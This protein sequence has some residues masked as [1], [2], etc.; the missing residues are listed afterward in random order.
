MGDDKPLRAFRPV[1]MPLH[2][3][4]WAPLLAALFAI[5]PGVFVFI[6]SN[7][8]KVALGQSS[9]LVVSFGL[10]AYL[11]AFV[12]AMGVLFVMM[13]I[14]PGKVVYAVYP[15]RL[16][17]AEGMLNW[18]RRTVFFSQVTDVRLSQ[19]LLQRAK[20]VG[21]VTVA[22]QQQ[23]DAGDGRAAGRFVQLRN[24]PEPGAVYELLTSLTPNSAT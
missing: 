2:F 10:I 23:T 9:N 5:F 1:V 7:V 15:D 22:T 6:M 12:A 19:G 8:V 24:V 14:E 16:D 17:Y 3:V 18:E 11:V 20:G 4:V 21:T 13:I